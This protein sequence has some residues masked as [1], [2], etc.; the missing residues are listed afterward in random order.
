MQIL[1]NSKLASAEGILSPEAPPHHPISEK[2]MLAQEGSK[3][4][5]KP[6]ICSFGRF[7]AGF[8]YSVHLLFSST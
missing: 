7:H 8:R 4:P 3:S 1:Q 5:S 6:M 2:G